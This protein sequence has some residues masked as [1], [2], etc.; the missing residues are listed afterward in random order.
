METDQQI[1]EEPVIVAQEH[2]EMESNVQQENVPI[3]HEEQK[4]NEFVLIG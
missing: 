3:Y 2:V 1:Q 4:E